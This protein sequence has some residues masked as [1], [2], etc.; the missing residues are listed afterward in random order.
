MEMYY[1]LKILLVIGGKKNLIPIKTKSTM[2]TPMDFGLKENTILMEKK[3]T[4]KTPINF[5]S[6]NE[7]DSNE[8]HIYYENSNGNIRDNR[9]SCENK[10]VEIEGV[11]YKL[12][13]L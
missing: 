2:K 5:G 6:K 7:Y 9:N 4:L 3:F 8:N 10:I 13:K 11:K 1:T 12:E